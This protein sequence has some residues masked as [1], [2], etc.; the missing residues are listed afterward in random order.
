MSRQDL[1]DLRRDLDDLRQAL[2]VEDFL[3]ADGILQAHDR[4]LRAFMAAVGQDAP[5]AAL[6]DLLAMQHRLQAE[7]GQAR[8]ARSQQLG[9]LR[10]SGQASRR[11]LEASP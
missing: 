2:Q 4:R 7:M 6:R 8:D 3:Q 10:R 5:L 11:Y 9:A 1:D